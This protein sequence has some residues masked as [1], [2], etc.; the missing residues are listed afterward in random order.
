MCV[1]LVL[2]FVKK[3]S[4]HVTAH[5][6]RVRKSSSIYGHIRLLE[7]V[8]YEL[9]LYVILNVPQ[10]CTFLET[11]LRPQNQITPIHS[12]LTLPKVAQNHYFIN[13]LLL[14][15]S[16]K[17]NIPSSKIATPDK[18]DIIPQS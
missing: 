8:F 4:S 14:Y 7:M 3:F 13:W 17:P 2:M 11:S 12:Y 6:K 10:R 5:E 1:P 18:N 16:T 15:A 9:H